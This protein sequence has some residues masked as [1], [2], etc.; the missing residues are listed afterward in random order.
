MLTKDGREMEERNV[1]AHNA[2]VA[3]VVEKEDYFRKNKRRIF[4]ERMQP[5]WAPTK[6]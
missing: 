6:N 3:T 1:A 5:R 4:E 2:Y